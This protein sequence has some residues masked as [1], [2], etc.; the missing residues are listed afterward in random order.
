[1]QLYFVKATY[2]NNVYKLSDFFLNGDYKTVATKMLDINFTPSDGNS[3]FITSSLALP[4]NS[5]IREYTHIIVP[6]YNKIYRINSVKYINKQQY[7][8]QLDDDPFIGNYLE[9]ESEDIILRRTNEPDLF[10]G[11]NDVSDLSLKETVQTKVIESDA[12][13]GKWALLFFQYTD[14]VNY[15]GLNYAKND[16]TEVFANKAA[17][18]AAYPEELT[19]EPSKYNYFQKIVYSTADAFYYQCVSYFNSTIGQNQLIWVFYGALSILK[20]KVYIEK[21]KVSKV[22]PV[23]VKSIVVALPFESDLYSG[24]DRILEYTNFVGPDDPALLMDIKIVDSIVIKH[25][26]A[27]YTYNSGTQIM[28][29]ALTF[30]NGTGN[31]VQAYDANTLLPAD[32]IANTGVL[33]LYDFEDEIDI[34]ANFDTSTDSPLK[35]EPFYKYDLYVYGNKFSIPYYLTNDIHI[36][37]SVVSGVV[38]Y[39]IY[40]NDRRNILGSGSFTHT[41]KYQVDQLDAFYSQNP[42]YKDQFYLKMGGNA[43]KTVAGGA[44]AGG[45]GVGMGVGAATGVFT[46]GVDAVLAGANLEYMEKGL[47]MK[48][49]QV[50]G[51]IAEVSLQVI[52]IFGIY[53]VKKT[54]EN[55]DLM[56]NEWY[57]RGFPT[58]YIESI[59]DL[60]YTTNGLFGTAKIIFGEIKNVIKNEYVTN[61]INEKLKQG[62]ILVP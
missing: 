53:W 18:L 3:D 13:T 36:L 5:S 60:S 50:F 42:T 49:D 40:Y 12:K 10:R 1:M 46:A 34:S 33:V 29:K 38:N 32:I 17:I 6:D 25:D 62:V 11:Q 44:L 37:I 41:I 23:E 16:T 39:I 54:P 51:E 2:T 21:T 52:N 47:R 59:D 56:L 9:L 8:I 58:S 28:K 20:D 48:P 4:D 19:T 31:V 7:L 45:A 35:A 61:N 26:V 14:T 57:L 27:T 24:T 43:F 30:P 22:N 15:L 55:Q